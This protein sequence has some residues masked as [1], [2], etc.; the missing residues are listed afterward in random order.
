MFVFEVVVVLVVAVA[1]AVVAV[2]VVAIL[3]VLLPASS[4]VSPTRLFAL[5]FFLVQKN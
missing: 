2:V 5:V 1:V 4:A 3:S